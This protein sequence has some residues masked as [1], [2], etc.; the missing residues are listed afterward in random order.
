M[1]RT[2]TSSL[3]YRLHLTMRRK[4]MFYLFQNLSLLYRLHLTMRRKQILYLSQELMKY[5]SQSGNSGESGL[6][7][8]RMIVLCPARDLRVTAT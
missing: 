3:L 6:R 5:W 1:W 4:Q 2:L 8:A 7:T